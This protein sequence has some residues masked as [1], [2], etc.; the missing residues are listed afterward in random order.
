ML[1]S[2][3]NA[4]SRWM[5]LIGEKKPTSIDSTD[6]LANLLL[7]MFE[8]HGAGLFLT[9]YKRPDPTLKALCQPTL[10]EASEATPSPKSK[11]L[12]NYR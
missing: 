12:T 2:R 4:I 7:H 1:S 8:Q 3:S 10:A 5:G 11:Q 9:S 6:M